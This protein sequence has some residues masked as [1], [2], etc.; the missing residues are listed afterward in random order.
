MSELGRLLQQGREAQ[1]LTLADTERNT[2][3]RSTY[4]AALEEG[5]RDLLPDVVYTR[6][7]V[8]NY[9]RYLGIDLG[10][11]SRLFATEYGR[12]LISSKE[13]GS[14]QPLAEPLQMASQSWVKALI[15]ILIVAAIGFALWWYWPVL[16]PWG[17]Y[18][19]LQARAPLRIA[20]ARAAPITVTATATLP[21]VGTTA[22]ARTPTGE[23]AAVATEPL[24]LPTSA[25]L[26]LPTPTTYV[27][28]TPTVSATATA[29]RVSG[30]GITVSATSPAWV[31]V[32]L[33]GSVAYE[34]TMATGDTREFRATDSVL[35]HTGN[36]GGM[37]VI[38]NGA[39]VGSLGDSGEVVR[40]LWLWRDGASVEA[41]PEA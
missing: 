15:A 19:L 21:A 5:R 30:L 23:P 3:I 14:H 37:Q 31:R 26:S 38:I 8:L 7:L 6:G 20:A 10:E 17:R 2:H 9:A 32:T 18:F 29:T 36:A 25:A 35:L 16:A 4:I 22:R 11:A 28:E 40:R 34:G 27:T 12:P 24:A 41:T 33:D 1:G 39:D 13:I